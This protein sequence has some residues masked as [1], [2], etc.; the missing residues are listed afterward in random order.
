[1]KKHFKAPWG[2]KLKVITAVFVAIIIV[3]SFTTDTTGSTIAIIVLLICATFAVRGYS[4]HNG[5]L[6][7]LRMGWST[8]Y[9]LS[10][11]TSAEFSPNATLGSIRTFGIGGLGGFIGYFR[12]SILGS[13]RAFATDAKNT[14]VLDFDGKKIVVTPENPEQFVQAVQREK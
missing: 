9:D 3:V 4:I 8:K 13:Y 6:L 2:T 14:V 10:K 7:I 11:L 1:M 12:N 5:Q